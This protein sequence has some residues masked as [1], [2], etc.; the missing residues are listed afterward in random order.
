V[1]LRRQHIHVESFCGNWNAFSKG[2]LIAEMVLL[3]LK[4]FQQNIAESSIS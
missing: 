2:L 1:L 4:H 3:K